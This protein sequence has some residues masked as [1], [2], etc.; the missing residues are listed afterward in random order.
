MASG[1]SGEASDHAP[2]SEVD[3]AASG[4]GGSSP[5]SKM[6]GIEA[7]VGLPNALPRAMA[8]RSVLGTDSPQ[9]SFS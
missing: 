7:G 5:R 6:E 4:L 8:R 2:A 3:A 9:N 1:V